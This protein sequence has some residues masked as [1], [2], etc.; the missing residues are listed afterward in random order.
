MEFCPECG[1]NLNDSV[2]F[3]PECGFKIEYGNTGNFR[4]NASN[5]TSEEYIQKTLYQSNE[6][7][8]DISPFKDEKKLVSA[9]NAIAKD[10]NPTTIIGTIDTSLLSNGKTGAVFTGTHLY[11]KESFGQSRIIPFEE[12]TSI[13]FKLDRTI[14]EKNKVK[15]TKVLKVF[16]ENKNEIEVTSDDLNDAYPLELIAKILEGICTEV[17]KVESKNQIYKLESLHPEIISLYFRIIIAYLRQD[18]NVVDTTEY[19][20]LVTLMTKVKVSKQIAD[21]IRTYR[22][23]EKTEDMDAL[24]SDLKV[25]LEKAQISHP[26]VFQALCMDIVSMNKKTLTDW[27]SSDSIKFI[28]EK[29]NVSEKLVEYKVREIQQFERIYTEK[30]DDNT[31]KNMATE[32]GALATGAGIS[33]GALAITGAVTGFGASLTGGL[34]SLAFASGGALFGAAAVAASAYGA[35]R[36]VKYFAGTDELEKYSIKQKALSDKITSLK[37]ANT[38][39]LDDFNYLMNTINELTIKIMKHQQLNKS[40]VSKSGEL[41]KEKNNYI[42]E[43][44]NQLQ[45]FVSRGQSVAESGQIIEKDQERMEL[46]QCLTTLPEELD[47]EKF[48]ELI[49]TNLH[50]VDYAELIHMTYLDDGEGKLILDKNQDLEQLQEV[51]MVLVSIKY[52]ETGSSSL[53]QGKVLAKKGFNSIKSF[54]NEA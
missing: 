19:K 47:L 54:F 20:E 1:N 28:I 11:M 17:E 45:G 8:I 33:M 26:V 3:C 31:I 22:F 48:N 37:A 15:E 16:Y 30:V 21:T 46:E 13:K 53:A 29:L 25:E 12:M 24:I 39:I 7:G 32:L 9:A 23:S 18:D 2:K 10:V 49:V 27:E 40:I 35:Y 4:G 6:K 34:M 5:L 38:F 41:I 51:S 50:K 36:G 14:D 43:L 52:F 44:T 42:E